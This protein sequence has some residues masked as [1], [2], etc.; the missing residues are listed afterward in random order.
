MLDH[1]LQR[2]I[3]YKL[4]LS[5]GLR[6]SELKPDSIENKLFDYHLKKVI[7]AGLAHKDTDGLYR[8]TPQGRRLGMRVLDSSQ[9]LVDRADSVLFL[10]IRRGESW[11]LY[12]R[13]SHPLRDQMGFM[14]AIP[15]AHEPVAT[16]AARECK[17][18]TGL[19]CEFKPLGGGYFTV[20][21]GEELE[22]FTHFT[23]VIAQ[24]VH[25]ELAQ[26][27]DL[28]DYCWV[29]NPDFSAPDML[30]NMVI[31]SKHCA[32][33]GPFFIEETFTLS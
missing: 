27:D 22:S 26:T 24:E 32:D 9:V 23:L 14:H 6:F 20:F 12:R 19:I 16:T 10:A 1:H 8:L 3:V 2:S 25:G 21:R 13:R 5:E 18:K 30:P 17:E 29:E 15:V 7:A 11:L 28:A 4:A 33:A 31:L